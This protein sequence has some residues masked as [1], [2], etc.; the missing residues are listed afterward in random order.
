MSDK[1]QKKR[2]K[3]LLAKLTGE[4]KPGVDFPSEKIKEILEE[5]R[6][7]R[8]A[9][10]KRRNSPPEET[11]TG[12]CVFCQ[13]KVIGRISREYRGDPMHRI[14]GPGGRNQ[15]TNVHHGFH[16]SRCGLRYEFP[17]PD[18]VDTYDNEHPREESEKTDQD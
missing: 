1:A 8:D 2:K 15:M 7:E 14:I 5:G 16:C 18:E 9:A 13:G 17:P 10:L 6:L 4:D 12:T 11:R 3:Q